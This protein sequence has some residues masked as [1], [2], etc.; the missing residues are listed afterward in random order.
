MIPLLESS[1]L[2]VTERRLD[3]DAESCTASLQPDWIFIEHSQQSPRDWQR[4]AFDVRRASPETPML[5][6]VAGGSEETAVAALRLGVEDYIAMPF[7]AHSLSEAL[8]RCA[9][10][11]RQCGQMVGRELDP[12]CDAM[13]GI[14]ETLSRVKNYMKRVAGSDCTVLITGETG[15]G[16]ELAAEFIHRQSIRR[17]KP[18]VCVNCAAI[19]DP[20]L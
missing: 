11:D 1:G 4:I 6:L 3:G 20:L 8:A 16:K 10:R 9:R 7:E 13:V 12:P 2:C 15:T 18:F 17:N 19:P 5:L 14:S